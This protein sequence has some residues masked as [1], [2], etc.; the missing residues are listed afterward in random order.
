M[1]GYGMFYFNVRDLVTRLDTRNGVGY[2][3]SVGLKFWS[4]YEKT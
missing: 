4:S 3:H 1:T 2:T